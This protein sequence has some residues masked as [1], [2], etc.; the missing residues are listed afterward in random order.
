MTGDTTHTI[1]VCHSNRNLVRMAMMQAAKNGVTLLVARDGKEVVT[2]ATGDVRPDAIVLSNDLKN[3]T[4]EEL[5]R[6]LHADPRLKGIQVIVLKGVLDGVG[7]MLKGF[8]RPPWNIHLP[9]A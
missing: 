6:T 7:Q 1:L 3:P 2:K 4:T 5:V 9:R 8:K